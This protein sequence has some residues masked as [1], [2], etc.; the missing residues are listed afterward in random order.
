MVINGSVTVDGTFDNGNGG[1]ITGSGI[2][3]TDEYQEMEPHSDT[4]QI[5][6]TVNHYQLNYYI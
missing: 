2:I 4:N 1:D 3:V 6:N 5:Q